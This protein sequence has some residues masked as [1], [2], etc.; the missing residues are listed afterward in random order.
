MRRCFFL[1]ALPWL[2]L[3]RAWADEPT[4][5][6]VASAIPAPLQDALKKLPQDFDHW[7]YTETRRMTD[8]KGRVKETIMRFDPSKPYAGQFAPI[9]IDGKEPTPRQ[10][11]DARKR[12][13]RRGQRLEREDGKVKPPS[14][15]PP[16]LNLNGSK[17][18]V[19]LEHAVRLPD[20]P[21]GGLLYEIPLKNDGK[22]S[23]PV[24]K[25]QLVVRLNAETHALENLA[26]KLRSSFRM[27]LIANI[28]SGEAN[29]DFTT[30]DPKFNNYPTLMSGDA[31][32][33]VFFISMGGKFEN[34]RTEFQR[35]KP[36]SEKFG[37]KIGPLK[38]LD[39]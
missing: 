21:A 35:V 32:V 11:D 3:V 27:K 38:A 37:V 6:A 2:V 39:F 10:L 17:V 20:A 13:E 16:T 34:K 24:E 26:L 7:A 18:A 36:Y 4:T 25:F 9:K 5:P 28:K 12:G 1:L 22:S 8:T 23:I 14:D 31:L 30:I 15:E 33:S 19:D 29:I